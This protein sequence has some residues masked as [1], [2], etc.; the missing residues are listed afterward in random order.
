MGYIYIYMFICLLIYIYIYIYLCIYIYMYA[1]ESLK[2]PLIGF[3]MGVLRPDNPSW[4][5]H[6]G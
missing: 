2:R 3:I 1:L 4:N 6:A 5:E